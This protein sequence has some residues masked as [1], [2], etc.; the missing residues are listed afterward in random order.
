MPTVSRPEPSRAATS[1]PPR[2]NDRVG[3]MM[4][5][6]PSSHASPSGC[7]VQLRADAGGCPGPSARRTA[8]DAEQRSDRERGAQREP[9]SELLPASAV[10]PDLAALYPPLP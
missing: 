7:V 1:R 5:S 6:E 4:R 8:Q 9:R 10:H 2:H 3:L